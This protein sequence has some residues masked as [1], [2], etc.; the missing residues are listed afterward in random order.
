MFKHTVFKVVLKKNIALSNTL[1]IMIMK[2]EAGKQ[3]SFNYW[4]ICLHGVFA[5]RR[6]RNG[7][8]DGKWLGNTWYLFVLIKSDWERL[9]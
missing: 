9:L 1:V 3:N 4:E 2:S 6:D 7:G 8:W 5:F